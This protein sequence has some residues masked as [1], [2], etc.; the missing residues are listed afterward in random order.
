MLQ[1]L[2]LKVAKSEI[3]FAKITYI[4]LEFLLTSK[5]F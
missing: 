4:V 1:E 5:V 2:A 3:W